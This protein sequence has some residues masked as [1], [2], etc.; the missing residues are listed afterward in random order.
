MGGRM[1]K[2][3][4]FY[5]SACLIALVKRLPKMDSVQAATVSSPM[6]S[7]GV[8][9]FCVRFAEAKFAAI[10]LDSLFSR[11]AFEKVH[12]DVE[13]AAA[14]WFGSTTQYFPKATK[15]GKL[16][17]AKTLTVPQLIE[18]YGISRSYAFQLKKE[19]RGNTS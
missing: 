5:F 3:D 2:I 13:K 1:S 14:Y 6:N 18:K 4:D 16:S 19:A 15:K 10:P 7:E 11:E 17:D 9:E 12:S 8:F